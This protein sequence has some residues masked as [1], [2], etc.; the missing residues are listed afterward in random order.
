MKIKLLDSFVYNRIAAGEVVERPASIVKE[1]VENSIDAGATHVIVSITGGGIKEISII[2]NGCGIDA[3]DI[4]LA[5]LPHATSKISTVDDLDTI[6]SFG[7][8]GEAL[9]SI[10]SVAKIRIKTKTKDAPT[11]T[12]CLLE[13]GKIS[14]TYMESGNTGTELV[15]SNLFYNTPARAK[16]LKKEKLE[17]NAVTQLMVRLI[18]A[19]PDVAFDYYVDGKQIYSISGKGLENCVKNIYGMQVFKELIYAESTRKGI[20]IKGYI[21]TPTYFKN[22]RNYQICVVNSRVIT[23]QTITTAAYRGYGGNLMKGAHPVMILCITMPTTELDVNVTP[24][25]S[26][27]RFVDGD[28]VFGA[29]YHFVVDAL[30]KDRLSKSSEMTRE[31]R[32][33][34]TEKPH[35]EVDE[36]FRTFTFDDPNAVVDSGNLSKGVAMSETQRSMRA[37]S[38]SPATST[39]VSDDD[40]S[41]GATIE[42]VAQNGGTDVPWLRGTARESDA[43]VVHQQTAA[44]IQIDEPTTGT[45]LSDKTGDDPHDEPQTESGFLS[46]TDNYRIVGQI[47][48]SFIILERGDS[49]YFI[50]EHAAVERLNYDRMMADMEKGQGETQMLMISE[51]IELE[52]H[53]V[54]KFAEIRS[55]LEKLGFEFQDFG[56]NR[57]K[58]NGIPLVLEG[59]NSELFLHSVLKEVFFENMHDVAYVHDKIARKACKAS[60]RAGVSLN[61]VQIKALMKYLI[62]D[63][64]MPLQC[65][66]GRPTIFAMKKSEIEKRFRRI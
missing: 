66:H 11:A 36:Y 31:L 50:D 43:E 23:N 19:N 59:L 60:V 24:N 41:D 45:V 55:S 35:S 32:G 25:K 9:A 44:V 8:R 16:Y 61:E 46:E 13:H 27:V 49:I 22:N 3:E 40:K 15:I 28:A 6:S 53:E 21:S 30:E 56:P 39:E 65:P 64:E 17:E 12:V 63:N 62:E 18:F 20:C 42:Q 7:F 48:N 33:D 34:T 5:F 54:Y 37:M 51:I 38:E 26:D 57:I 58:I 10:A 29:V 14:E 2:D 52:D 47:F 1:T 4:E